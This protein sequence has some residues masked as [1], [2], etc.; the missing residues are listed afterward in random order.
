MLE[1]S[2]VNTLVDVGGGP[3]L[4]AIEFV[5]RNPELRAIVFD[6]EETLQ[7]ATKNIEAA[8]L[9]EQIDLCPGDIFSDPLP[10]N[11][12]YIFLSNLVHI[13]SLEENQAFIKSCSEALNPGGDVLGDGVNIGDKSFT[14]SRDDGISN[15]I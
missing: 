9:K 3:G 8:G 15:R 7:V 5:K 13:Y 2:G 4:Y 11:V 1:L 14:I 6:S 12:D 10:K